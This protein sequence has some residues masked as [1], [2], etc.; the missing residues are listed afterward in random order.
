MSQDNPPP[1]ATAVLGGLD[2][3]LAL[4]SAVNR[5]VVAHTFLVQAIQE[6]PGV[7]PEAANALA[8]HFEEVQAAG[9][10]VDEAVAALN[11]ATAAPGMAPAHD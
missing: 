9:R 5:L 10:S 11:K 7:G 1:L 4:T 3:I 6:I 2:A 8:R